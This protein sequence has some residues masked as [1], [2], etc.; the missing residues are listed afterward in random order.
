MGLQA[1]LQKFSRNDRQIVIYRYPAGAMYQS[2]VFTTK[3]A[4]K[5]QAWASVQ[6]VQTDFHPD[7]SSTAGKSTRLSIAVKV[8]TEVEIML[9]NPSTQQRADRIIIDGVMYEAR[10]QGKYGHISLGH[11]ETI[12][13]KVADK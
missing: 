13:V 8:F 7:I 11:Y 9:D 2:G 5:I 6:P 1:L 4:T 10:S 3:I 12:C